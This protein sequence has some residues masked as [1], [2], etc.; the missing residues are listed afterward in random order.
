MEKG[1]ESRKLRPEEREDERRGTVEV[2]SP[3]II[4]FKRLNA[5]RLPKAGGYDE[6]ERVCLRKRSG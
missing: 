5:Q 2:Q 4:G 3:W 6:V 1:S